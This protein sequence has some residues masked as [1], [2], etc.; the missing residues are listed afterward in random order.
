MDEEYP[1]LV[2]HANL[3]LKKCNGLPLAIVTIGG[4]LANQ[5]KTVMEWRK[6]NEHIRAEFVMNPELG[7][8]RTILMRSYDGLPY[9]LKSCFLYMPIFPEDCRVGRKRLVC[10]WTAEGYSREV[11]GKSAEEILDSYFMELISRSMFLPCQKSAHGMEGI[12]SCQLHDLIRDIGISKSMEEN[13]VLTLEEGCSSNSQG[14]MHHLAINGNWKGD[15]SEFESTVDMSRVRSVTCFG[16][17]KSF[18]I[19]DKMSSLRVLDLE[20]T[21]GLRDHHL[22]HI[23]RLLHL[24]YLSLRVVI[25]ITCQIHWVT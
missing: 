3:I 16:E 8:V 12:G 6:L 21:T 18:F 13:L 15:R 11:H 14:T 17:W 5:P 9:H 23:G 7:T 1:E 25:S 24:R 2:E 20:D 10:R 19:S 22:K 4:V